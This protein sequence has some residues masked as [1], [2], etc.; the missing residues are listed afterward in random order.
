MAKKKKATML[1]IAEALNISVNA[2][3]LALN[4]KKGVS[5]SVR[6]KVLETASAL[7]YLDRNPRFLNPAGRH[8]FCVMMQDMYL[9]DGFYNEVLHA[10]VAEARDNGYDTLLQH[11]NDETM[12]IPDCIV[13]RRISGLIILG[14]IAVGNVERLQAL[15]V[16][17]VIVD[18]PP[19]LSNIHYV[20][21]DNRSGGF[22]ATRRLIRAGFTKIGFFGDLSYTIS[23]RDRYYGF[24]EALYQEGFIKTGYEEAYTRR[25]SITGGI[26][27]FIRSQN[28]DAVLAVLPERS[29]LPQ[30]FFC[31]NDSA[32]NILIKALAKKDVSVPKDISV[33]GFDN[34]ASSKTMEPQL[35]TI[36]VNK[37]LLG[38][39]AV[40]QLLRLISGNNR[41]VMHILL[42]VELV[43]RASVGSCR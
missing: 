32:A 33:I 19:L 9:M 34:I 39:T 17:M 15:S 21:T 2:V 7:G 28:I 16:L 22:L 42:G 26:E 35:T 40:K 3:S 13:Q 10:V 1:D 6:I 24:V 30:A 11:F 31:S 27:P 4:D 12:T 29:G 20:L 5:D 37:D 36:N 23:V 38:R 18:H 14:K 43:E 8:T 41:E 25:F